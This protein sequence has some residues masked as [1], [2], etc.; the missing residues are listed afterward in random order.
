MAQD[1]SSKGITLNDTGS[2]N[3]DILYNSSTDCLAKKCLIVLPGISCEL[4]DAMPLTVEVPLEIVSILPDGSPFLASHID[5]VRKYCIRSTVGCPYNL[6][7]AHQSIGTTQLVNAINSKQF[8]TDS[9][10]TILE[11]MFVAGRTLCVG[12]GHFRTNLCSNT[13]AL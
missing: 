5:I 3:D 13:V 6:R 2:V 11:L 4:Q 10:D 7:I 8:A 1:T 9:A 12:I